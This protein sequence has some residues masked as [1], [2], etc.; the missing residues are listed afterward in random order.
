MRIIHIAGRQVQ[1]QSFD[2]DLDK[3]VVVFTGAN[4][5]GKTTRL[6]A[7]EL[8]LRGPGKQDSRLGEKASV[9]LRLEVPG[10]VHPGG[11][12]EVLRGLTPKHTLALQPLVAQG[13]KSLSATQGQLDAL[14]Q[15]VPAVFDVRAFTGLSSDKQKAAILPYATHVPATGYA[16]LYEAVPPFEGEAGSDYLGRVALAIRDE[17]NALN[18]KRQSAEKAS[19]ELANKDD[20][21]NT[22]AAAQ[23]RSE[24]AALDATVAGL[25]QCVGGRAAVNDATTRL[26]VAMDDQER[27]AATAPPDVPPPPA[28]GSD[29]VRAQV[30]EADQV[31]RA[32]GEAQQLNGQVAQMARDLERAR[33]ETKR[34]QDQLQALGCDVPAEDVDVL[35]RQ[36]A[37]VQTGLAESARL[38]AESERLRR[39]LV[40]AAPAQLLPRAL[41]ARALGAAVLG[42]GDPEALVL[43]RAVL[44]ESGYPCTANLQTQLAASDSLR[45][46]VFVP[47]NAESEAQTLPGRIAQAQRVQIQAQTRK[48]IEGMVAQAKAL[49]AQAEQLWQT[50]AARSKYDPVGHQEAVSWAQGLQAELSQVIAIE[51]RRAGVAAQAQALDQARNDIGARVKALDEALQQATAANAAQLAAAQVRVFE[52]DQA[53]A[54]T[55]AARPALQ[56]ELDAAIRAEGKLQAEQAAFA[57]AEQA[58]ARIDLLKDLDKRVKE[59]SDDCLRQSMGKVAEAF[60]PFAA[61]LGAQ[62]RLGIEAPLGLDRNGQWISYENLSDSEQLVF[63]IGLVLALSTLGQGLRVVLLDNLDA[64]DQARRAGIAAVAAQL[65]QQGRLDQVIGTAW[66]PEG[67]WLNDNVQVVEVRPAAQ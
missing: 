15:L 14:T 57:D 21:R 66:S 62:W 51:Q 39:E 35:Q 53:L 45:Q 26:R 12:V 46:S 36:L 9:H 16:H 37:E 22:R 30:N 34:L 55:E 1:G 19:L 38:A 3:P 33:A 2:H 13:S 52:L 27:I 8:A 43:L 11:R 32:W 40:A 67:F 60:Q 24:L 42:H 6:K 50:A 54:Q 28:R 44:E 7:I 49:E 58:K 59:A 31:M 48:S 4:G 61:L 63:G 47:F 18:A 29:Q 25:R 20:S 5:A 17:I 10:S 56:A 64:C 41:L 65:V 23:I